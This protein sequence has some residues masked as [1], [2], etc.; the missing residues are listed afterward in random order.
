MK[1]F[2]RSTRPIT[3]IALASAAIGG[4]V[5]AVA[6]PAAPAEAAVCVSQMTGTGTGMG[7]AGGGSRKAKANAI[8]NWTSNVRAQHGP[9]YASF[10]RARA[11]RTSCRGG[12][13]VEARC[14]VSAQPCR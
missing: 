11:V 8:A 10:G 13:V 12:L 14:T 1:L 4:L 3:T 5:A 2:T 9:G 7:I 6:L